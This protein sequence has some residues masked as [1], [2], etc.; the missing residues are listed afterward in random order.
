MIDCII[1]KHNYSLWRYCT[2]KFD[3][4]KN[5]H[6]TYGEYKSSPVLVIGNHSFI[7]VSAQGCSLALKANGEIWAWGDNAYGQ[8]GDGT[9]NDHYYPVQ[10]NGLTDVIAVD[11]GDYYSL[12][13]KN[14]GT[15][16]GCGV[17]L[18]PKRRLQKRSTQA[19]CC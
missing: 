9:T 12:F 6:G 4:I 7:E 14:D 5:E 15:V 17:W 2:N 10:I 11:G 8:L 19:R 1:R 16:W 13:L 3:I 18:H